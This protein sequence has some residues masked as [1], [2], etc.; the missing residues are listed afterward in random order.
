MDAQTIATI[1]VVITAIVLLIS[2]FL[3]AGILGTLFGGFVESYLF[4]RK[5]KRF[6]PIF[7]KLIDQNPPIK[8][9]IDLF[10]SIF[11]ITD[12]DNPEF[13][14]KID[15]CLEDFKTW[16]LEN[17]SPS[18]DQR[19]KINRIIEEINQKY[20]F[21]ELKPENQIFFEGFKKGI[22]NREY[23]AS[24]TKLIELSNIFSSQNKDLKE[25]AKKERYAIGLSIIGIVVGICGIFL[26]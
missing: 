11:N 17:F 10:K 24:L 14:S 5:I 13:V 12:K 6:N 22:V 20:E 4:E 23:E 25:M 21:T 19:N 8:D 2:I 1:M 9:V 7:D 26:H 16:K 3:F 15:I 18:Q